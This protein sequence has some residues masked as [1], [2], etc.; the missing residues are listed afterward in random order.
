MG[1]RVSQ[2]TPKLDW[3]A[4]CRA[5][6][7]DGSIRRG[8]SPVSGVSLVFANASPDTITRASG[9]WITDGYGVNSAI[10]VSGATNGANNGAFLVTAITSTKLTVV[11]VQGGGDAG[12]VAETTSAATVKPTVDGASA[13]DLNDRVLDVDNED[14]TK[15]GIYVVRAGAAGWPRADD[16]DTSEKVTSG[17]TVAVYPGSLR[18]LGDGTAGIYVLKTPDPIVLG[19][20]ELEFANTS[21]QLGGLPFKTSNPND[22]EVVYWNGN[23]QRFSTIPLSS[24]GAGGGFA[25]DGVMNTALQTTGFLMDAASATDLPITK[26]KGNIHYVSGSTAIETIT[27]ASD[28]Q[29]GSV[30]VLMF[31]AAGCQVKCAQAFT[32]DKANFSLVGGLDFW[33][34]SSA[35]DML[36][37]VKKQS[38]WYE[39]ARS[40]KMSGLGE[41]ASASTVTLP[42]D[43]DM[44]TVTGTTT[45]NRIASAKIPP[46]KVITLYL[47]DGGGTLK[48][49]QS[50]S[51]SDLGLV[52]SG[53]VDL[54]WGPGDCVTFRQF[55]TQWREIARSLS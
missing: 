50:N 6:T 9:S 5:A 16:A 28:W 31:A 30:I 1:F 41:V 15:R 37:L 36:V 54:A 52:L 10:M 17:L 2:L 49:G 4:S 13:L 27:P 35:T 14:A 34:T 48:H 39:V 43:A 22:G 42:T 29:D 32:G 53:G 26:A 7:V 44:L 38:T 45:I 55:G 40:Q 21:Y 12:L 51:G 24:L 20:S 46:G 11:S 25:D 19:Y 47:R 3:K 8:G 23:D 33:S 18:A